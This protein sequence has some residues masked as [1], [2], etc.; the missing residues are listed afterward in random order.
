KD[1][2]AGRPYAGWRAALR[3]KAIVLRAERSAGVQQKDRDAVIDRQRRVRL[4][5]QEHRDRR[6]GRGLRWNVHAP[7]RDRLAIA[8]HWLGRRS[9][10]VAIGVDRAALV[11]MLERGGPH[12]AFLRQ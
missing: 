12:E 11:R 6:A 1:W 9:A 2:L 10:V 4:P 5:P 3:R 8:R 7:Q